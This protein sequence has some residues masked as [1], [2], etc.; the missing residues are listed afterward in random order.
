MGQL[1]QYLED[2]AAGKGNTVLLSGEA[3]IGKTTLVDEFARL[4]SGSGLELIR[5]GASADTVAPFL[6]FSQALE[7]L[8]DQ[9]LFSELEHTS[10]A[11]IFVIN[12]AGL[13]VAQSL[14]SSEGLDGD[15]FS[16][17]LSA[18][19][20][21]VRD[22]LDKVGQSRAGLGR[23]EY[24]DMKILIEQG[25][26]VF[27][28][29]VLHGAEHPDMQRL[30]SD[31]MR[32]ICT[33]Y[34]DVLSSWTGDVAEVSGVQDLISELATARFMVRRSL[35][36]VELQNE[37][38]RIARQVLDTLV[39]AQPLVV[40]LEDIHWADESSLFVLGFLANFI[41]TE[42]ILILGT[43]RPD[44]SDPLSKALDN[45][46]HA[47]V[48]DLSSFSSGSVSDLVDELFSPNEFPAEFLSELTGQCGGNPFFLAETL[49]HMVEAGAIGLHEGVHKLLR[50]DISIP[51]SV[52]D[53]VHRRL[54]TLEPDAISLAEY[55]SC[56]GR[57]FEVSLTASSFVPDSASSLTKLC[58]A[59]ILRRTNGAV[60]FTHALYQD[61]IYRGVGE[62]W[63]MTYHRSI[64]EHLEFNYQVNEVL[65]DLARHFSHTNEHNKAFDYCLWAA[66]AAENAYAV[67][68]AV[69]LYRQALERLPRLRDVPTAQV[70]AR[71]REPIADLIGMLGDYPSSID[72]YRRIESITDDDSVRARMHR[73]CSETYEKLGDY[74]EAFASVEEAKRFLG[75][76]RMEYSRVLMAE[77]GVV[78]KTGGYD[79]AIAI[80]RVAIGVLEV[81]G[82]GGVDLANAYRILGNQ[83]LY[84]G[85]MEQAEESYNKSLEL[86]EKS[87]FE[88]GIASAYNNL[89]IVHR[90]RKEF[91][92][93]VK[94]Y[95]KAK[96]YKERI[97]DLISIG[98]I[99]HNLANLHV[100]RGD[101]KKAMMHYKDGLELREKIGDK[102]GI[103]SSLNGLAGFHFNQG[104]LDTA[105]EYIDRSLNMSR[106]M[107]DVHGQ[108]STLCNKGIILKN[109]G[110]LEGAKRFISESLKLRQRIGDKYGQG[111]SLYNLGNVN[112][113]LG[114]LEEARDYFEQGIVMKAKVSD[115]QGISY[116]H[117][118]LAEVFLQ[119]GDTEKA[120][121]EAEEAVSIAL[122][123]GVRLE[124][125]MGK[126]V[127][128]MVKRE[129]GETE[130]ALE[131]FARAKA[132]LEECGERKVIAEVVYEEALLHRKTGDTIKANELLS[133]ALT[134]FEMFGMKLWADK[135]RAEMQKP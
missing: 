66:E 105:I 15:I 10:F 79:R 64:G 49:R 3:G 45:M 29:A 129:T 108:G 134:E 104:D 30:L 24:G 38:M 55:A 89:G 51:G 14:S 81:E 11:E 87:D 12:R 1:I 133:E 113:A 78:C 101:L 111:L 56:I 9:P 106:N 115:R 98:M 6:I 70:E 8:L 31:T 16:G 68:Q 85:D 22:S 46:S 84:L 97:G 26:G 120:L 17:M 126:K 61:V 47:T 35:E 135:V 88:W 109:K 21:F 13:L 48:M 52:E 77:A 4:A 75:D 93:A 119:E 53:L 18:I 27:L 39:G 60:E 73:K 20:E 57:G 67:G 95:E 36:G 23:V 34:G 102:F 42:K 114:E 62:R 99:L 125:G 41:R 32:R 117:R 128:G 5:G 100:D 80:I 69:E 131:E 132:V 2:A 19:Q 74:D 110:D 86:S 58:E 63:K 116:C 43:M 118:G 124:E 121:A 37:R 122:E 72:E 28:S 76:D 50:D 127:L 123:L 107:G 71:I 44:E 96:V 7:D 25:E 92:K 65:F 33:G 94:C 91:N 59:G 103:A 83:Y 90:T 82:G 40:V 112:L 54:E 130:A